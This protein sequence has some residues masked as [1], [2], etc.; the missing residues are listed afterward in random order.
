[1]SRRF[2]AIVLCAC[3][4]LGCAPSPASKRVAVTGKADAVANTEAAKLLLARFGASILSNNGA[5]VGGV[6]QGPPG[7]LS[8]NGA[9]IISNNGS[10]IIS[11]AGGSAV[12]ARWRVASST[13][14]VPLPG[15]T[16]RLLDAAGKPVLGPNRQPVT[17]T[18]NAKGRYAFDPA[19]VPKGNL[20]VSV[21]VDGGHLAAMV[22]QGFDKPAVDL[23]LVSTMTTT[24][25]TSKYVEGQANPQ[26][27]FNK[28]PLTLEEQTRA[29]ARAALDAPGA[30][31]PTVLGT[32]A[33]VAAVE[34]LRARD[35]GLDDRLA[36]VRRVLI[37]AGQSELGSGRDGAAV[38]LD[39]PE[40]LA[41]DDA[42][43]AWVY[44]GNDRRVWRL[45][46]DN[47]LTIAAGNGRTPTPTLPL[48][49]RAADVG[50]YEVR[51][52]GPDG[53]GGLLIIEDLDP[54]AEPLSARAMRLSRL[55][56][57]GSL[58]T[59]ASG[60]A[61]VFG[62]TADAAGEPIVLGHRGRRLTTF[63]CQGG[64]FVPSPG[65]GIR[66]GDRADVTRYT[67]CEV[68]RDRRFVISTGQIV[69]PVAQ[70]LVPAE[71]A[72]RMVVR[73]VL[74]AR[75]SV[76][77]AK[78]RQLC[79]N[80]GSLYEVRDGQDVLVAGAQ[81]SD[82]EQAS[83][84]ALARPA[85]LAVLP[86]GDMV[87]A[88]QQA[89]AIFRISIDGRSS[90]LPLNSPIEDPAVL[91]VDGAGD[92]YVTQTSTTQSRILRVTSAGQVT[93]VVRAANDAHIFE[94]GGIGVTGTT[95][96]EWIQ[97]FV[98]GDG[99]DI[100]Y[101]T[102]DQVQRR[103]R[104]YRR[105]GEATTM[106]LEVKYPRYNYLPLAF[107][108]GVLYVLDASPGKGV[109]SLWTENT[110]LIKARQDAQ[111][112]ALD[113]VP[114]SLVAGRDSIREALTPNQHG[115]KIEVDH[116][117]R[118]YVANQSFDRVVRFDALT[119]ELKVIAGR[120]GTHFNGT[121]VDNGLKFPGQL[122]FDRQGNL[123]FTDIG[124]KQVKRV[125]AGEL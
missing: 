73:Y 10:G 58:M 86:S 34:G 98:P 89:G 66:G 75:S 52:I 49:A 25:I 19:L 64:A 5:A 83:D 109:L 85:G 121:G 11:N 118:V 76:A 77:S 71:A 51:A 70:D 113:T 36:T 116:R 33:V 32:E 18:T 45:A 101:S 67:T 90:R 56:A 13:D 92:V 20:R 97:D 4:M 103:G 23:D 39:Y 80:D 91:R 29:A 55:G 59:L 123:T 69:D 7:L 79:L 2:P 110:G 41:V 96:M 8:N 57:D 28:L 1:M 47:T 102:V 72:E 87:L 117:G 100:F 125:P 22:P 108:A 115:V 88:D 65:A 74:R 124:N 99:G 107:G 21:D 50:L 15:R 78:G 17:A 111:F 93:E 40:L 6:V 84:L 27:T 14:Q 30:S 60:S 12:G 63:T 16:V 120:D 42:G 37:P 44:T 46:T 122:A 106:L 95:R 112:A 94:G 62:V 104:V 43:T 54:D 3:L 38:R 24:Y 68:T 35:K 26:A 114:T 105:H 119:E 81:S 48:G 61:L 53:R 9:G 31:L 82:A